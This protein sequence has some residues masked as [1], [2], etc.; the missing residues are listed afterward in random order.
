MC[1]ILYTRSE[2]SLHPIT[3]FNTLQ[4]NVAKRIIIDSAQQIP[5][6]P[7]LHVQEIRRNHIIQRSRT[8][9]RLIVERNRTSNRTSLVQVQGLP[10]P[11]DAVNHGVVH[12]KHGVIGAAEKVAS[13]AADGEVAR[14]V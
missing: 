7:R 4:V 5:N 10:E 3:T 12:E 8:T 2:Q 6:L 13:V 11:V 14:G 9:R 1:L